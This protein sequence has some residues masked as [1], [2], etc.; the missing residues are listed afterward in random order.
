MYSFGKRSRRNL[1]G[2]HPYLAFFAERLIEYTDSDFSVFEG[3]RSLS[4][5]RSY[6]RKGRTHTMDSYHLYGLAIDLVPYYKGRNIWDGVIADQMFEEIKIVVDVNFRID[7][8]D[9]LGG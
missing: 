9:A 3:V 8:A 7:E 6:F 1:V 5:Q 4:K 2:V